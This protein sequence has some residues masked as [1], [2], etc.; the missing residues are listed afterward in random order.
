MQI[1]ETLHKLT[2]DGV[3][4]QLKQLVAEREQISLDVLVQS[5]TRPAAGERLIE[6]TNRLHMLAMQAL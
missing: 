3:T 2:D 1:Q 6:L 5:I 4:T